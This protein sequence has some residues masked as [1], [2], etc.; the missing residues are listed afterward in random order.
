MPILY[1]ETSSES[2]GTFLKFVFKRLWKERDDPAMNFSFKKPD[3]AGS[4][5]FQ[6]SGAKNRY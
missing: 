6:L 3:S 5:L 4:S 2:I 1:P